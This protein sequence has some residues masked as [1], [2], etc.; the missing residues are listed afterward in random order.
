MKGVGMGTYTDE[1]KSAII[2]M[3]TFLPFAPSH[4]VIGSPIAHSMS[5]LLHQH[6]F[7]LISVPFSYD[8]YHLEEKDLASFLD[9]FRGKSVHVDFTP[10]QIAEHLG[11]FSP[12]TSMLSK[13]KHDDFI[14]LSNRMSGLSVTLPHKKHIM[15]YVDRVTPLCQLVGAA[16]TLYWDDETLM[17]HNTDVEGF[18]SP[19][20][21]HYSI[22]ST[23]IGISDSYENFATSP[24]NEG[25]R[26]LILGAGG[27]AAAVL[28]GLLHVQGLSAIY[29]C[30]R[31]EEQARE[32]YDHIENA[33]LQRSLTVTKNIQQS[34]STKILQDRLKYVEIIPYAEREIRAELLINT[35][36][37]TLQ[38]SL[39][40]H[41]FSPREDFEHVHI[42][43]DLLYTDT[44]FLLQA[45]VHGV[46]CI[47]GRE[48]FF[49]Q[50]A[51]QF[52]LWTHT[53][54]PTSAF[55]AVNLCLD[56]KP[57]ID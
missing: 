52:Y 51:A 8:A 7:N 39:E 21:A 15:R 3:P 9:Y 19:L 14:Q 30:A 11:L 42:A 55:D 4:G 32:L 57:Y 31:R 56:G 2:P 20:H 27:A 22:S 28:V 47:N 12:K 33:L 13:I 43:Y 18:L 41:V 35:I 26:A 25:H 23:Y 45:K 1:Q 37:A 50:G 36:P 24:Q 5:P 54:M 34:C 46:Q 16:N 48:M 17:G 49:K 6:G 38:K 44:P 29:L 53:S 10:L 40:G